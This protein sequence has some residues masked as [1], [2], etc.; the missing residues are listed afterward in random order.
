MSLDA[1]AAALLHVTLIGSE[2]T[3]KTTLASELARRFGTAWVPEAA[4]LAAQAKRTPLESADV[5]RIA[6][7]HIAA[8]QQA[9]HRAQ[10]LL[11]LDTDLVSTLVYSLHY[12]GSCP[13]WLRRE[14][15]ARLAGLYLLHHPDVPWLPDP[16]RDRGDRRQEMHELFR[17]ALAALGA[18]VADIRGDWQTR[19]RIAV[20]AIEALLAER[21]TVPAARQEPG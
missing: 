10:R 15:R 2:C 6:H 5:E 19:E 9:T 20:A 14:A 13:D 8:A 4:R 7:S 11:I 3:G 17:E 12:Y 16:A 21:A 18:R 1:S